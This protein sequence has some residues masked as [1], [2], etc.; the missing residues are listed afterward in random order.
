MKGAMVTLEQLY[1]PKCRKEY[2]ANFA[3]TEF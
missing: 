2:S 3:M 1:S